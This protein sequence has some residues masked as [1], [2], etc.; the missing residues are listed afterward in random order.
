M[1]K[2]LTTI[3]YAIAASFAAKG[4][5]PAEQ[6]VEE[7]VADRATNAQS[8]AVMIT[9]LKSGEQIAG[10]NE[11][12]PLVPASIMKT[13]TIGT[14]LKK[15]GNEYR[16]HTLLL[17][18]GRVRDGVLEG[19]L[20]IRGSGD[21]SLNSPKGP[22]SGDFITECTKAIAERGVD[23]I[24]GRIILDADVF[25][26][27]STPPSWM[28]GDLSQA[29]GAGC[30]GINFESNASGS[31]SVSNPGA[32]LERR[33]RNSLSS[34]GVKIGDNSIRQQR[35]QIWLD[36]ASAPAD[37]IMRSCMM[38][39]DNLFAEAFLRTYALE[40]SGEG[41]TEK[42]AEAERRYWSRKGLP[43]EGVKIVDGSGLSRSNRMTAKFLSE[44]LKEMSDD[45]YY[46]SFFPL[47]GQEGTLRR[48]LAGTPLDSY[49][50]L[51]TGSMN[52]IQCYAGYKLDDNYAPT[53]SVVI[54]INDMKARRS[55]VKQAAERMLMHVFVPE[56]RIQEAE[57][58]ITE[59]EEDD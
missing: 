48:F 35:E 59:D 20:I 24:A 11:T 7:F 2:F 41:S 6:A 18:D 32:V 37:E 46:V 21:P 22:A 44:V 55:S 43:M 30:F 29:Y 19:N 39:S 58:E 9:D 36:H 34:K 26:G 54:M 25:T 53:H 16:Y 28:R 40:N 31:R 14:L 42:G 27:P 4:I 38:R 33:L 57:P 23:S 5:G 50:A 47:A 56:S 1:N 15:I 51:K 45:A 52:G 8:I 17:A 3:I 10:Y 13:V 12:L 49:I